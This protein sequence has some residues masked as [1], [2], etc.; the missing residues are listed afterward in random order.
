MKRALVTAAT[1]T[2]ALTLVACGSEEPSTTG[3]SPTNAGTSAPD[4]AAE[5]KNEADV[6]FAQGMILHHAE[7]IEMSDVLLGKDGVDERVVALAERIKAAQQPEI[8][9]MT[10]WL[11]Q[12]GEDVP[13]PGMEGMSMEGM[14][15][16]GTMSEEDMQALE[17]AEGQDAARLFLEQMTEHHRGAVAMAEDEVD[18]GQNGDAVDLAESIIETQN[19]EIDEMQQLLSS[20]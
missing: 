17:S 20:L 12:W 15:M 9:Q 5:E 19:A 3:E 1:V 6:M 14:D 2:V 4:A 18:N 11:E 16:G 8:E 13:D 10:A 7:A